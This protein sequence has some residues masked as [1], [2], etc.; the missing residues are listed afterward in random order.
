MPHA[1]IV[2]FRPQMT[3]Y[4]DDQPRAELSRLSIP[5]RHH[6]SCRL[7][8]HR[9]S[10]SF[11]DAQDLLAQR[12]ITVTYETIRQWCLTFGPSLRPEGAM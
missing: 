11:R 9:F 3:G 5:A 2:N 7:L 4:A 12:G 8:Y 10:L 1:G 6:Q